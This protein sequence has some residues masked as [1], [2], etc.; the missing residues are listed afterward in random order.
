MSLYNPN[1]NYFLVVIKETDGELEF[2]HRLVIEASDDLDAAIKAENIA[3][4]WHGFDYTQEGDW[5]YYE[6]VGLSGKVDYVKPITP[7]E[8]FEEAIFVLQ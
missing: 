6:N 8:F 7:M 1:A 5:I 2:S 3:R 4:D